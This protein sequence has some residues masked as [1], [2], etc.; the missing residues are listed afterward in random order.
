VGQY[1]VDID[2]AP[3][4]STLI[5]NEWAKKAYLPTGVHFCHWAAPEVTG[6]AETV[7]QTVMSVAAYALIIV[8]TIQS[9]RIANLRY[10]IA[11]GYANLAKDRWDR[12]ASRFKPFEAYL[13]NLLMNDPEI[14]VD[15]EEAR[16]VYTECAADPGWETRWR[17]TALRYGLCPDRS[18]GRAARVAEGLRLDDLVNLAYRDA[19][20]IA[21]LRDIDRWNRRL[22]LLNTGRDLASLSTS[23][24]RSGD[25]ILE[26]GMQSAGAGI[27]AAIGFL[28]YL[29]EAKQTAYSDLGIMMPV[30]SGTGGV[31]GSA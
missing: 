9:I 21:N 27:S 4:L 23:A 25:A 2:S 14:S 15:Y 29:H 12:F 1:S 17:R 16:R 20:D 11:K 19:E 13:I 6:T 28:T 3:V 10:D 18:L 24:A 5:T 22:M 31:S 7:F 26:Q 8:N 30:L